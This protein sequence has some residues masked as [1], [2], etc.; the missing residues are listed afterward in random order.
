MV[1]EVEV[2]RSTAGSG[3]FTLVGRAYGLCTIQ[4]GPWMRLLFINSCRVSTTK[5]A[6]EKISDGTANR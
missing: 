2:D 1:C 5:I 6:I 4:R 3:H